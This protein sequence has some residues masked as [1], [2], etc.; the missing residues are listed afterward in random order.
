MCRNLCRRLLASLPAKYLTAKYLN[1]LWQRQ[2]QRQQ[3]TFSFTF[4]G[5]LLF[6]AG[7][8]GIFY[9]EPLLI[10]MMCDAFVRCLQNMFAFLCLQQAKMPLAD[11]QLIEQGEE[12]EK[13]LPICWP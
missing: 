9:A 2:Q 3:H 12:M 7:I 11:Y 6:L 4:A 10:L 5:P 8:A 1:L 13:T